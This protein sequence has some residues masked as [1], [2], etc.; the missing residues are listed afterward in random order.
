MVYQRSLEDCNDCHQQ[1]KQAAFWRRD[2]E[3]VKWSHL[4]SVAANWR[5][6]CDAPGMPSGRRNVGVAALQLTQQLQLQL[7]RPRRC[8]VFI[9]PLYLQ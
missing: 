3:L 1:K 7:Q 4:E 5:D 8:R 9:K 6:S 2:R